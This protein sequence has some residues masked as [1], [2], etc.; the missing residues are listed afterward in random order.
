MMAKMEI[1]VIDAYVYTLTDNEIRGYQR[2]VKK[3]LG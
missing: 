3:I 2:E 1:R